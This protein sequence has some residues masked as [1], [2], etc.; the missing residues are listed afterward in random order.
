M[1][2]AAGGGDRRALAV[3]ASVGRRTFFGWSKAFYGSNQMTLFWGACFLITNDP[4]FHCLPKHHAP[5][6]FSLSFSHLVL[7]ICYDC[8]ATCICIQL[9]AVVPLQD[10]AEIAARIPFP[11]AGP[12]ATTKFLDRKFVCLNA[13]RK[14]RTSIPCL[15]WSACRCDRA[16]RGFHVRW[17]RVGSFDGRS[18]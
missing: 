13:V 8:C 10:R 6:C 14:L 1:L 12:F 17:R 18:R 16:K 5:E 9:I 15:F 4:P 7:L 11:T 2:A 3:R